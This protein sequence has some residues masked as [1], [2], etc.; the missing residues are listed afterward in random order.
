LPSLTDFFFCK[1]EKKNAKKNQ[2][3]KRMAEG[4]CATIFCIGLCTFL[5]G[6]SIYI[7]LA[8]LLEPD[9]IL[10]E[11]CTLLN[12][13]IDEK[14]YECYGTIPHP[15][16]KDPDF[17]FQLIDIYHYYI[18][19]D[20][21]EKEVCGEALET[22]QCCIDSKCVETEANGLVSFG[23]APVFHFKNVSIDDITCYEDKS[24]FVYWQQRTNHTSRNI[25]LLLLGLFMITPFVALFIFLPLF[26][27]TMRACSYRRRY[28]V[29]MI[30][31]Q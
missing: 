26:T 27:C 7:A 12:Y 9:R 31:L 6:M 15:G 14:A 24:G 23:C 17:C 4:D 21:E 19:Y 3:K 10:H 22:C 25:I 8:S 18:S 5:G 28:Y 1:K 20:G 16:S 2:Q 30:E 29:H 11:N 13:S